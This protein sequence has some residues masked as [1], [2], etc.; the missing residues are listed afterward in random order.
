MEIIY[1]YQLEKRPLAIVLFFAVSIFVP[2][3]KCSLLR[4]NQRS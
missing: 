3:I 1:K 4:S 2:C